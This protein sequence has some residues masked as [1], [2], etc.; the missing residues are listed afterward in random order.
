M[1][2]SLSCSHCQRKGIRSDE[3][4]C[5]HSRMKPT[6]KK[7]QIY[8]ETS[9][10]VRIEGK[11]VKALFNPSSQKTFLGKAVADLVITITEAV[12][13]KLIIRK[14][15]SLESVTYIPVKIGTRRNNVV[16][17]EGYI[18]KNIAEKTV[19]LGM[20]AI[21][22]LGFK[23]YIGGQEAKARIQRVATSK[24]ANLKRNTPNKPIGK[25]QTNEEDDIISFLDE[26]ERRQILE[27]E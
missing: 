24:Q 3:C 11:T 4:P 2:S 9:I 13:K 17:V 16:T 12:P 23:F 8:I 5:R 26:E 15:R 1:P 22:S 27:W 10:L 19:I 7:P 18:D 20:D 21:K 14:K 25:K 6:T